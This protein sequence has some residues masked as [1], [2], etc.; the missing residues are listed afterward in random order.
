MP[1]LAGTEKSGGIH[2]LD[3][4]TY[5]DWKAGFGTDRAVVRLIAQLPPESPMI[6]GPKH[7]RYRIRPEDSFREKGL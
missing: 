3:P 2:N 7:T 4:P 6:Q 5:D 1:L